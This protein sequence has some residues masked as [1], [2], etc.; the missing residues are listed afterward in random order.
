MDQQR[1]RTSN[2]PLRY[3]NTWRVRR[4]KI[5]AESEIDQ[6]DRHVV[7]QDDDAKM[8]VYTAVEQLGVG[9]TKR[10]ALALLG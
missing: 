3:K 7:T 1:E 4:I 5:I 2:V 10:Q 6:Y 9:L 8:V